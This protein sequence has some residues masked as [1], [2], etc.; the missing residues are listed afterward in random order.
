[1]RDLPN[2]LSRIVISPSGKFTSVSASRTASP[3]RMPVSREQA[4]QMVIRV[5]AESAR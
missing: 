5:A 4:D 2:L 3:L 1:M